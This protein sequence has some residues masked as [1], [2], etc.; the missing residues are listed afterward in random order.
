MMIILSPPPFQPP[1]WR[2]TREHWGK[3]GH[4]KQKWK[5]SGT[6]VLPGIPNLPI[7]GPKGAIRT[8]PVFVVQLP[9]IPWNRE[10]KNILV[11]TVLFTDPCKGNVADMGHSVPL[12]MAQAW[13]TL[14]GVTM[15]DEANPQLWLP[16]SL[17]SSSHKR[18]GKW[19][20]SVIATLCP[21]LD[22]ER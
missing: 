12:L 20:S 2:C 8:I 4:E 1:Q 19:V 18:P 5:A 16:P 17:C 14:L 3:R 9:L 21:R 7:T 15:E 13:A 11:V 6:E 22:E 10:W